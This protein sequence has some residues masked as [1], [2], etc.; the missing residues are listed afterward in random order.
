M[1]IGIDDVKQ[2]VNKVTQGGGNYTP[3]EIEL[4]KMVVRYR[5]TMAGSLTKRQGCSTTF[6]RST[7][8]SITPNSPLT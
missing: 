3:L 7:V 5:Q 6:T 2:I 4:A 1:K 8:Q